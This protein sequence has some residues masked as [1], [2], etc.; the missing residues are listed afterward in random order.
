LV[1]SATH[2]TFYLFPAFLYGVSSLYACYGYIEKKITFKYKNA[3]DEA[4]ETGNESVDLLAWVERAIKVM[5]IRRLLARFWDALKQIRNLRIEVSHSSLLTF[6]ALSTILFL[7]FIVRL[8]PIRWGY[9]LSE[10]DP[11]FQFRFTEHLVENGIFSQWVDWV[12]YQRWYPYGH[13]SGRALPGLPLTAAV[14]HNIVTGL[15]FSVSIYDLCVM[16]PVIFGT[17]TCLA[18]FFLGRLFG[19][20]LPGLFSALFLALNPSHISRTSLG[21]FDDETVGVFGIV[22]FAYFL[23]KSLDR[24]RTANS[25]IAYSIGAGLALGYVCASWGAALY[26]VGIGTVFFFALILLRRYSSRLLLSYTVTFGLG[27]FIAINVPKLSTSF[28]L[29]WAV[30]PALGVFILLFLSEIFRFVESTKWKVL[31]IIALFAILIGGLVALSALGF[32]KG[33][34]GR[35]FSVLNPFEREG[36][37]LVQSVAE[38]R[39]TAWGS[40]YYDFG[41][42]VF[43]F[44]LGL[45]FAVRDLTNRNLFLL[46]FGFTSLYFAASMVRLTLIL[47]PAFCVLWALGLV[48]LVKPFVDIIKQAPSVSPVRRREF[49][50]VGKE[51]SGMAMI[52][53]FLLLAFTF[54]LPTQRVFS[55]AYSPVTIMAGSLPIKPAAPV[56]EWVDALN[57]M[58]T[59]LSADAVV[60]SWWDYGYWITIRGNKTSLVDN[61]TINKTQIQNIGYIFMSSE[62]EAVTMLKRYDATH[63]LVFITFREDNGNDIGYGDEG[64]WRWMARI[65][66]DSGR[67]DFED[68][69]DFGYYNYTEQAWIWNERGVRSTFYG[70]VMYAKSQKVSVGASEPDYFDLVYPWRDGEAVGGVNSYGGI[71][72]L[73]AI[74]EIDY[75][76]YELD[77]AG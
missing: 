32:V 13:S 39:V 16:F 12:D 70:L 4:K 3:L 28:L 49:G 30:L 54:V 45:Y 37:P 47:A 62:T 25:S 72:P 2:F 11:Y 52:L 15:G 61:A 17:L 75:D 69:D 57:W 55:H 1:F 23:L 65:A 60:C 66:G 27:L 46:V 10:F 36:I 18:V 38:H 35:F 59:E 40:L 5:R 22:L 64:K 34:T 76:A 8:L 68:E 9:E 50:F 44:M 21:F 14:L 58:E 7:A 29:T 63:I 71:V 6:S 43:F 42:G 24:E 31:S 67:F 33:I 48:H 20:N 26:P 51:F 56:T 74:Y 19:G 77:Y 41:V 73:V 53:V